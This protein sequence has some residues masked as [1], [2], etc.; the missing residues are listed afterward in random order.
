MVIRGLFDGLC[1]A[2]RAHSVCHAANEDLF[3]GTPIRAATSWRVYLVSHGCSLLV[4][5]L[6]G[7][8]MILRI[9]AGFRPVKCEF[10]VH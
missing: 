6:V 5:P 9:R 3:A 10:R 2:G 4:L 7:R 1:P 8:E